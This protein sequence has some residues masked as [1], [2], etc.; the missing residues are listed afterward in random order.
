MDSHCCLLIYPGN[1][2]KNVIH[3]FNL[4]KCQS[5]LQPMANFAIP[6][7]IWE[8]ITACLTFTQNFCSL[9]NLKK[10]E[11][12][13]CICGGVVLKVNML[14]PAFHQAAEGLHQAAEG[15]VVLVLHWNSLWV[16]MCRWFCHRVECVRRFLM[17]MVNAVKTKIIICRTGLDLL[18]SSVPMPCLSYRTVP[19][20]SLSYRSRQATTAYKYWVH[21]KCIGLQQMTPNRDYRCQT[22]HGNCQLYWLK[23]YWWGLILKEKRLH[24]DV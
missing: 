14:I 19:M 23:S 5:R 8:K 12:V 22:V 6:L 9:K 17:L 10:N 13:C 16:P 20:H 1:V 3:C 11:N 15:L 24:W 7:S 21:K 18:Q 4:F 2:R